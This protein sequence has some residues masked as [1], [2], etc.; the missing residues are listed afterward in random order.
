MTEV[1][2]G[3]V[4]RNGV[5]TIIGDGLQFGAYG[6]RVSAERA[7]RRLAKQSSGLPVKLHIQDESGELK[8]PE[9]LE[10]PET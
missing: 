10:S 9:H 3:V 2:Y 6:S 1:N 4:Q 7:A 5:W 8:P